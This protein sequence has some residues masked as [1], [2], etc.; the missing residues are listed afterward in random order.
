MCHRSP[1]TVPAVACSALRR[2]VSGS[3]GV[4]SATASTR[5]AF[6]SSRGSSRGALEA[7]EAASP[8][9][10]WF[11]SASSRRATYRVRPDTRTWLGAGSPKAAA[12]NDGA[13]IAVPTSTAQSGKYART[14]S[15]RPGLKTPSTSRMS[16]FSSRARNAA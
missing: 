16:G 7:L 14:W 4:P 9:S 15:P 10:T 13:D 5:S 12:A 2:R 8:Q 11:G 1:R 6:C 3:R